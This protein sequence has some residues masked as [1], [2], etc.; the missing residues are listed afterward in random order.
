[1]TYGRTQG[2]RLDMMICR[3]FEKG[4]HEESC[5]VEAK[6]FSIS[7]NNEICGYNVYKTAI[8]CQGGINKTM[9]SRGIKSGVQTFGAHICGMFIHSFSLFDHGRF[10]FNYLV[11]Q[12]GI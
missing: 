4:E 9:L 8:L 12:E 1:V 7:R 5:F 2:K 3:I 11:K 6:H 10:V